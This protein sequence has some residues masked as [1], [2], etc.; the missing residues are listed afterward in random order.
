MLFPDV[1]YSF[2]PTYARLWGVPF[3]AVPLRGDFAICA[4]DYA[5]PSGG[6]AIPNPNAPT[7]IAL[8][9]GQVLEMARGLEAQGRVLVLDEAYAGFGAESAIGSIGGHPN[10]LVTRTLSKSGSLAGLRAGYAV[11][12]EPLIEGLCRMRDSFNSYTVD[13][14]AMAGA[15]AAVSDA[16]YYEETARMVIATRERAAEGLRSL[17]FEVL[18]SAA[19]FVFARPPGIGGAEFFAEL[20]SRGIL[21][22]HFGGGRAA[23]FL[24]VSIGTDGEMDEFLGRC[25]EI[26]EARRRRAAT[27]RAGGGAG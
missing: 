2:Y 7:G 5:G 27:A 1:T 3:R 9:L 15:A 4:E 24:R 26:I 17:G 12:S 10:L 21:V 19:N 13:R 6:A 23:D 8:P 11:G 16:E 25:G 22:R 20:R 14:L 18:P